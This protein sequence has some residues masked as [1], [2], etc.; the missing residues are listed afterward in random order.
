M[1]LY[2]SKMMDIFSNENDLLKHRIRVTE[3]ESV[4]TSATRVI[5]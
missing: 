5:E 2:Q 4:V 1:D 3:P